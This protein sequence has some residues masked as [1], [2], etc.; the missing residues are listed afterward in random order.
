[1]FKQAFLTFARTR[2]HC[3]HRAFP[4]TQCDISF[5]TRSA[6]SRYLTK[7]FLRQTVSRSFKSLPPFT[8]TE[9]L[10]RQFSTVE[11]SASWPAFTPSYCTRKSLMGCTASLRSGQKFCI[12][13]RLMKLYINQLMSLVE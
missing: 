7:H 6:E 5:C 8:L 13:R 2:N 4:C 12:Y 10:P 3:F 9:H 1:M 11:R